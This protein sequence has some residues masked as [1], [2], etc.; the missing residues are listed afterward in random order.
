MGALASVRTRQSCV[1]HSSAPPACSRDQEAGRPLH[2][3]WTR[4]RH[5]APC[6]AF[7]R[8]PLHSP[9]VAAGL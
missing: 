5:R 2:C 3:L 6:R 9:C 7:R 4:Q 8:H 1:A